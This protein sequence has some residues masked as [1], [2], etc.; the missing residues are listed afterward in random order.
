[1]ELIFFCLLMMETHSVALTQRSQ[2]TTLNIET[3]AIGA[4]LD[5]GQI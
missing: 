5:F 3:L 4:F 1:M 2:D